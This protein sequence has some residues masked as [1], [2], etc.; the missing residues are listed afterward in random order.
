MPAQKRPLPSS[1]SPGPD[2]RNAL[3]EAPDADAEGC[4][5]GRSPKQMVNGA[6]AA[7][8][9]TRREKERRDGTEHFDDA[10]VADAVS[11]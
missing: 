5:G 9:G 6:A 3:A 2:G 11:S 1:A 7:E 4:N 8:E 10:R